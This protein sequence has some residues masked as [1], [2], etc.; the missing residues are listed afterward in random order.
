MLFR[1]MVKAGRGADVNHP[2][3]FLNEKVIHH[4]SFR[5]DGLSPDAGRRGFQVFPLDFRDQPLEGSYKR[6]MMMNSLKNF[7]KKP[8]LT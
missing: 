1:S 5:G 6:S 7:L 4:V 3:A 2:L 8:N